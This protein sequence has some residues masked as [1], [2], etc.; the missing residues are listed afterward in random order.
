MMLRLIS[1]P[2]MCFLL[3]LCSTPS[4]G[5]RFHR[6]ARRMP[7]FGQASRL[8]AG[9]AIPSGYNGTAIT[10]GG[11]NYTFKPHRTRPKSPDP[12]TAIATLPF[13]PGGPEIPATTT[14]PV[15]S[16]CNLPDEPQSCIT[17]YDTQT[18]SCST[19]LTGFFTKVPITD[20]SQSVTF[21]S[22]SSFLLTSTTLPAKAGIF[23]SPT[24][25]TYVQSVVSYSIAPYQ[26]IVADDMSNITV[27]VCTYNM[28]D[29]ETC[30]QGQE[31]WEVHMDYVTI[32]STA[33]L[34]T[35]LTIS[36]PFSSVSDK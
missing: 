28:D 35:T 19:V 26:S 30:T 9:T 29:T 24:T 16:I 6:H 2:S 12:S 14:S 31:Y 33:T 25:S 7:F 27:V 36:D 1:L 10:T 23:R 32:S 3:L 4:S 21:S 18:T 11:H 13:N 15:Y 20:C 17:A 8:S 34:T 22:Q 5:Q